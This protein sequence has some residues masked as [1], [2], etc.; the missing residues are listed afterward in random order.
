MRWGVEKRNLRRFSKNLLKY[1]LIILGSFASLI[2]LLA[3]I[4][5]NLYDAFQGVLGAV[6]TLRCLTFVVF[7]SLVY[8]ALVKA[9]LFLRYGRKTSARTSALAKKGMEVKAGRTKKSA[10]I[11]NDKKKKKKQALF[12]GFRRFFAE[13]KELKK[14]KEKILEEEKKIMAQQLKREEAVL[15]QLS[16]DLPPAA[17]QQKV[18]WAQ[19][20]K[21]MFKEQ[22]KHFKNKI[23]DILSKA[24]LAKTSEERRR[25]IKEKRREKMDKY[26]ADMRKRAEIEHRKL[27]E[28]R[29]R[30][31]NYREMGLLDIEEG[32]AKFFSYVRSKARVAKSK[33]ERESAK[34]HIEKKY[35]DLQTK[36]RRDLRAH[37]EKKQELARK[38][39]FHAKTMAFL[40]K[41]G[42]EDA[43]Q[44]AKQETGM[45][46]ADKGEVVPVGFL[47]KWRLRRIKKKLDRQ[48]LKVIKQLCKE[49]EELLEKGEPEQAK[50]IFESMIIMWRDISP[51]YQQ[52][53][54][55][56]LK[57]LHARLLYSLYHEE[58]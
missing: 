37:L 2:V 42:F 58:Q 3:V 30:M 39:K 4:Q 34:E 44:K 15:R 25:I 46:S 11:I 48:E 16:T 56:E 7:M 12:S 53:S 8:L 41:V 9:V 10:R 54:E 49:V 5:T 23:L 6:L 45:A 33:K 13:R 19:G 32:I 14:K 43:E 51:K 36:I 24:H 57:E 40:K 50:I 38:R 31:K 47:G 22:F 55:N 52:K 1:F 28:E 21:H 29:K 26:F 18:K 20:R 27:L 17:Q 35:S